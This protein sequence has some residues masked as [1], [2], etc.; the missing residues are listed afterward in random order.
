MAHFKRVRSASYT[1][2]GL[3]AGGQPVT[4]HGYRILET[5]GSTNLTLLIQ[6][7]AVIANQDN[8]DLGAYISTTIAAGSNTVNLNTI[9]AS[10]TTISV[11]STVNLQVSGT[12]NIV[13]PA[14]PGPGPGGSWQVNYT[15]LG[16]G[17]LTGCTSPPGAPFG[18]AVLLT[19]QLVFGNLTKAETGFTA[20]SSGGTTVAGEI[21]VKSTWSTGGFGWP[22]EGVYFEEGLYFYGTGSTGFSGSIWYS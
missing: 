18:S 19:G 8:T 16:S 1:A 5:G 22:S 7:G 13:V 14:S 3:L 2:N 11:A 9:P 15:G 20:P 6:T 21:I 12:V 4:L 17:T 10:T